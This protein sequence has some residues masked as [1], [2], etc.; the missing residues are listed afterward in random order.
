MGETPLQ[1]FYQKTRQRTKDRNVFGGK[2]DTWS[3]NPV[4]S[5]RVS[6]LENKINVYERNI[7]KETG[8]HFL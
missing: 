7:R 2:K 3:T 4:C 8:H 5:I 1:G 6:D